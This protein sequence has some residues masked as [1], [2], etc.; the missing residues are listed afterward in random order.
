MAEIQGPKVTTVEPRYKIHL[1]PEHFGSFIGEFKMAA[2][3]S[4]L[5]KVNSFS[6][7]ISTMLIKVYS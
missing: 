4:T 2:V 6:Y 3:S 5:A 1:G 7:N